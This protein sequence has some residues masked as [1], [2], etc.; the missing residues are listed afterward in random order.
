MSFED[1]PKDT[2]EYECEGCGGTISKNEAGFWECDSC[3][4]TSN[5]EKKKEKEDG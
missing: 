5:L 3:S 4:W 1:N 2:K